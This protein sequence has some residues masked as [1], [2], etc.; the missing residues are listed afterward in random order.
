MSST[1]QTS[2]H[3]ILLPP[4]L[5]ITVFE[6]LRESSQLPSDVDDY[7]FRNYMVNRGW[8]QRGDEAD[9]YAI[10]ACSL[11][12]KAWRRETL[13]YLLEEMS[14]AI[15]RGDLLSD[16]WAPDLTRCVAHLFHRTKR[17]QLTYTLIQRSD[18]QSELNALDKVLSQCSDLQM[19]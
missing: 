17:L 13:K 3:T 9:S 8:L 4:E 5:W 18:S 19:L 6:A 12:C 1:N 2:T 14:W 7:R 11:V 15:G 10:R 16:Q